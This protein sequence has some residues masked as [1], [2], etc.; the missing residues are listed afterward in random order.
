M[1]I[2]VDEFRQILSES[3]QANSDLTAEEKFEDE[4]SKNP[5]KVFKAAGIKIV[6]E[7]KNRHELEKS[8][9]G[10]NRPVFDLGKEMYLGL[11][12]EGYALV[13]RQYVEHSD[14]TDTDRTG[15]IG[16]YESYK[17]ITKELPK[18]IKKYYGKSKTWKQWSDWSNGKPGSV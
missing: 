2:M 9:Y 11:S 8:W 5:I 15:W 12:D 10:A 18:D 14:K 17:E 7:I 3:K 4:L 13:F 6:K 16:S 1:D